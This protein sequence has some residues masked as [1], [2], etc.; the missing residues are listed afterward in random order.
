MTEP[1]QQTI[2]TVGMILKPHLTR[3]AEVIRDIS[4]L[5][6]GRSV[7]LL[8]E[9]AVKEIAPDCEARFIEREQIPA[10][11]DLILV[12]GGDGTII[13]TSRLLAGRPVPVM[14]INFGSL[15]YLTEFT[16]DG[17]IPSME[18]VLEGRTKI[19]GRMMLSVKVLRGAEIIAEF[20]LLNDA[21][22][23]KSALARIVEIETSVDDVHVST[24]RADG[25]ILA[26][27]TGST[28][29]SLSAGGPIVHPAMDAILMTPICPH[30]LTNR[31]LV[32]PPDS[33]IT[34]RL[35][36][37]PEDVLV[38]LDGQIGIPLTVQD[39]VTVRA[40]PRRFH[41]VQP[42]DKNYFHVL[43]DKLRWGQ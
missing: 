31:P 15:G 39:L 33:V 3:A 7:A 28:A 25:M 42:I 34:M 35:A 37:P 41:L 4:R 32:I 26:T 17:L 14:G 30:T 12:L 38:T 24:F 5:L 20:D 22:V 6:S 2:E 9:P 36:S 1:P 23:N 19:A 8:A 29:Y 16:L 10:L 13:A 18:A 43:R 21:V 27:P 40:S 11:A